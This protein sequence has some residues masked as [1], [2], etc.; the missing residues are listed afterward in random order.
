[1][2]R[3][4]DANLNRIGEALRLLED[5]SRFLLNDPALTEELKAMRHELLPRDLQ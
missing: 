2:L 1:M 5:I 4:L 3:I